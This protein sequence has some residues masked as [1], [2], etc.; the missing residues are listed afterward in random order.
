VSIGGLLCLAVVVGGVIAVLVRRRRRPR[1][2]FNPVA[3]YA[4]G[5][6]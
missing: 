5:V 3:D 2:A 6:P 4:H 1:Q